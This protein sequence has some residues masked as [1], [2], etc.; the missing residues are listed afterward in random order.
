M[1]NKK[2]IRIKAFK[3]AVITLAD[4]NVEFAAAG[5]KSREMEEMWNQLRQSKGRFD[6]FVGHKGY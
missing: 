1:S 2:F 3:P 5:E 6:K 4:A